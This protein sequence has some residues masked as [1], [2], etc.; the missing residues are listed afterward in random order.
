MALA[1][2]GS[3]RPVSMTMYSCQPC[4]PLPQCRSR[5]SPAKSATS[6]SRERVRRLNS[7]DL[8]T[9]ARPT[10]AMT[11]FIGR[12][13]DQSGRKPPTAP[14]RV[15]I[16]SVSAA[17][18]GA[19][20]M[21][22]PS[23]AMRFS[24][25]PSVRDRKCTQPVSSPTTTERPSSS[26]AVSLRCLSR[27]LS[28]S[29]VP[30]LRRQAMTVPLLSVPKMA[31]PS[32]STPS[33]PLAA[34]V[35]RTAPRA[36]SAHPTPPP[37]APKEPTPSPPRPPCPERSARIRC[38]RPGC[39]GRPIR[40]GARHRCCRARWPAA[41][42]SAGCR[43]R[44]RCPPGVRTGPPPRY[45]RPP[46]APPPA[47][48]PAVRRGA[49]RPI[50][51]ARWPRHRPLPNGLR[52]A[53]KPGR[54]PPRALSTPVRSAPRASARGRNRRRSARCCA[55]PP[56][57]TCRR[58]RRRP[59]RIPRAPCAKDRP[60]CAHRWQRARHRRWPA[61]PQGRQCARPAAG[62]QRCQC[63]PSRPAERRGSG[64]SP[65]NLPGR[66]WHCHCHCPR[67]SIRSPPPAAA[68]RPRRATAATCRTPCPESPDWPSWLP[69][70]R[71]RGSRILW[72]GTQRVELDLDQTPVLQAVLEPLVRLAVLGNGLRALVLQ[73]QDVAL[74]VGD[75]GGKG[76]GKAAGQL[77][78]RFLVVF[79]IHQQARKPQP[80]Q[81]LEPL[82]GRLLR[83]PLPRLLG[84]IGLA[85]ILRRLGKGQARLRGLRRARVFGLQIAKSLLHACLV[86][87]P[88]GHIR[89]IPQCCGL[90]P[91]PPR[92]I[93]PPPNRAGPGPPCRFCQ[94]W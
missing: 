84:A 78:Q 73:P 89:H 58:C 2:S 39:C 82:I 74:A 68:A 28:H 47:A 75:D 57:P 24:G 90:G 26:G 93:P 9:F 81:R 16:T 53:R 31:S 85:R 67:M 25:V 50:A 66:V 64:H 80:G 22:E 29:R 51:G 13:S 40:P 79:L 43:C 83:Q 76:T 46:A 91:P 37:P 71:R 45:H 55:T 27:S 60:P 86:A 70:L 87:R 69:G 38:R 8:P 19:A 63:A 62:R 5:V 59:T 3:K 21:P 61:S 88:H 20:A 54:R 42:P 44:D 30:S 94:Y 11:G 32:P 23:V 15:T 34:R 35:Q 18:V 14:L 56:P 52:R 65:P 4:L 41:L 77:L 10:R 92:P 17:T 6:A 12:P 7:V 48:G 49:A 36:V 1:T 72:R 33:A